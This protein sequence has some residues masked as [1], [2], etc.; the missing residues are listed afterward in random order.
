M[1]VRDMIIFLVENESNNSELGAKVR[2]YYYENLK[3]NYATT[4]TKS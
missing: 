3:S 2:E 1:T 4:K